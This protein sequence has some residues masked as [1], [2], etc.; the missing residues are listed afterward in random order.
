MH[1]WT[2]LAVVKGSLNGQ[3]VDVGILASRHLRLLDGADAAL[4]VQDEDGDILLSLQAVDGSR[5]G[6]ILSVSKSPIW[7]G[8]GASLHRRLLR[9]RRSN[10]AYLL[11][12]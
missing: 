6:L 4:G 2:Y 3:V 5:S 1:A 9:P 12:G 10:D 8:S 11:A 7:L